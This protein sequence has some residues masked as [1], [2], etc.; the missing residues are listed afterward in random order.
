[1]RN[2][3]R[4]VQRLLPERDLDRAKVASLVDAAVAQVDAASSIINDTRRL[5][6]R[7]AAD[8]PT[9]SVSESVELCLRL[10]QGE[11]R[12]AG[13]VVRQAIGTRMRVH[14][15]PVK[16][17]QVMLN[18]LRNAIEALDG[19]DPAMI[20]IAADPAGADKVE[21]SVC[22]TGPGISDEVRA[23]L[24]KPFATSKESGLGLGLNLSRSI[25]EDHGGE[26]WIKDYGPGQT[27]IAFTLRLAAA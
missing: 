1:V 24:F 22:D 12:S 4:A 8:T 19:R 25:I 13:V 14:I 10:L 21:I 6:K 5:V 11:M 17:Q 16:L 3:I 26:L 23:E 7:D 15:P 2:F 9:A 18:L 20:V 27:C